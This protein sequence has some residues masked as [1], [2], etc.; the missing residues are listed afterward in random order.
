MALAVSPARGA[1][2]YANG[3][4]DSSSG[5]EMTQ[6]IQTEDFAL[7]STAIVTDVRFWAL[8][9]G[10]QGGIYWQVYSDSAGNPG[11][12]LYSGYATPT[13]ASYPGAGCCGMSGYQFD[14]SVGSISL[15]GGVPYHL[16]LHNGPLATTTRMDFYWSTAAGNATGSG[17]E[18]D[19]LGA[20]SWYNNGQEHA[21]EL[22]GGAGVPEPATTAL[23]GAGLA[24]LAAARFRRK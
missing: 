22:Y 7:A 9:P 16:G 23:M 2:I 21:F 14:F 1:V 20:T 4:P 8:G 19:L 5:N 6:W 15:T 13:V 11:S 17:L 18:W 12:V 3:V 10:Y 24:L